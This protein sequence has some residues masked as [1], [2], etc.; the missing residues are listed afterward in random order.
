MLFLP[1][2]RQSSKYTP[3]W[4][5]VCNLRHR[6]EQRH[7]MHILKGALLFETLHSKRSLKIGP[8]RRRFHAPNKVAHSGNIMLT[9]R[10]YVRVRLILGRSKETS[11]A[12]SHKFLH[13]VRD[14][15]WSISLTWCAKFCRPTHNYYSLE[16]T[17]FSKRSCSAAAAAA[18]WVKFRAAFCFLS[19]AGLLI[20]W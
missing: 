6:Y 13:R 20:E 19:L 11:L 10:Q 1:L 17:L 3:I 4:Q 9:S 2:Q 8:W 15:L 12:R 16:S 14:G 18:D 5:R 7:S